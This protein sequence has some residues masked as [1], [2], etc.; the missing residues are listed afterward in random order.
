MFHPQPIPGAEPVPVSD[1]VLSLFLSLTFLHSLPI[2]VPVPV[3][4]LNTVPVPIPVPETGL[5]KQWWNRAASHR[6]NVMAS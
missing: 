4:S 3:Q 1:H 2:P 6:Q 5:L